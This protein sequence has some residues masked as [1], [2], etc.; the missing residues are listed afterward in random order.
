MLFFFVGCTAYD[1]VINPSLLDKF[2]KSEL[3]KNFFLMIMFEG[4]QE[5][6]GLELNKEW[7][8]LKNR[9]CMGTLLP[10]CVR[11]RSKPVIME[12]QSNTAAEE[13]KA[14][15]EPGNYLLL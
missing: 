9:K 1:I 8:I 11:V 13:I 12:M 15:K 3:F 5:K 7:T 14:E 6:Y 4:M 2:H 10:H